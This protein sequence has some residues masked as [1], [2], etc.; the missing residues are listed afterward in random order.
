M[1]AR[2]EGPRVEAVDGRSPSS[3]GVAPAPGGGARDSWQ[4]RAVLRSRSVRSIGF[5]VCCVLSLA[6]GAFGAPNA[7]T[8]AAAARERV[9]ADQGVYVE[10]SDGTVLVSQAADRA[11]HPASVSK[12]PTT[13]A[14]LK[15]LGPTHQFDTRFA[16]SGPVV[17]G[18]LEGDLV[19]DASGDP[20]L[21]DENA[22]LVLRALVEGGVREVRGGLV[23]R[24]PFL[25]DWE[26]Q[27]ASER[28]RRVLAGGAPA[29]AWQAVRAGAETTTPPALRFRGDGR[30]GGGPEVLL[31]THRSQPLIPLVK[32]LN[33]YSN[34][35][36]APFARA[37][38]GIGQVEAIARASVSSELRD[39]IVLGDG[40]GA[41]PRNRLSPRA[42]VALLRALDGELARYDHTLADVLPVAGVDEGTLRHRLDGP[43]ERGVVT[44][45]TGTYGDY[46]ASALAGALRTRSHGTVYFAVLNHG[47]PVDSARGRQDAFVR[48]LLAEV[49]AEP[50]PYVRDEAPAFTRA[51][52]EPG[53]GLAAGQDAGR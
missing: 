49:D 25:F 29:P 36:F 22:L 33:G 12:V 11:V 43:G 24:G 3:L 23:V 26:S 31:V 35:I 51:K 39:E 1:S 17:G 6:G 10:T 18:V 34:N 45:K 7:A 8:L 14:L 9:G 20:Y 32:A 27:G 48:A 28:L 40:A 16:G 42:T 5:V 13:L 30:A 2:G 47:V 44:G 50:W 19:V 37:A 15:T 46:G 52:L 41:S 4:N 53:D 38:G 21:V